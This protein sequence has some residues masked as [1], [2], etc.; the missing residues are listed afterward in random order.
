MKVSTEIDNNFGYEKITQLVD[1][2]PLKP[3]AFVQQNILQLIKIQTKIYTILKIECQ[4]I[5]ILYPTLPCPRV[6][7]KHV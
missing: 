4:A 6:Q 3:N 7:N 1:N 2:I 5:K